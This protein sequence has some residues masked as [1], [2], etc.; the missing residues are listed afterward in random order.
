[1]NV[2]ILVNMKVVAVWLEVHL[3]ALWTLR[4]PSC[5]E[6]APGT[7]LQP[8]LGSTR[9]VRGQ[10]SHT[11]GV[12]IVPRGFKGALPGTSR[13]T[14][15]QGNR[16]TEPQ[17]DLSPSPHSESSHQADTHTHTD[18]LLRH[19]AFYR[20]VKEEIC[21]NNDKGVYVEI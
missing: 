6:P 11:V 8:G 13:S 5:P 17:V 18:E 21:K 20:R 14:S 10:Y 12:N 3:E 4:T 1:M 19:A 7:R 9:G 16:G 2:N 15:S